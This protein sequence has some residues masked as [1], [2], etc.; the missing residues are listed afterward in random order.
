M[1]SPIS[2]VLICFFLE[3]SSSSFHNILPKNAEYFCYKDNYDLS[4]Q[5]KLLHVINK[6]NGIEFIIELNS[7]MRKKR[8]GVCVCMCVYVYDINKYLIFNKNIL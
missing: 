4:T 6:L 3:F 1:G 8:V 5:S 7:H 2:S